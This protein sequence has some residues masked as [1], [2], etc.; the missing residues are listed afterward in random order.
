MKSR[1]STLIH[2]P[3]DEVFRFVANLEKLSG[4]QGSTAQMTQL[5]PGPMQVGVQLRRIAQG[6]GGRFES[7]GEVIEYEPNR[8]WGYKTTS[9]AYD[10]VMR[11]HLEPVG[12]DTRLT[13]EVGGDAKGFFALFNLVGP[14]VVWATEKGLKDDLARLKNVLESQL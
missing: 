14:L 10:W 3:L 5:T 11:F 1:V 7:T 8:Q 9:S 12:D 4:W 2:R 13:L 6:P